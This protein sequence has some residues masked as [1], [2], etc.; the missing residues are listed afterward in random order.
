[1]EKLTAKEEEVMQVVWQA[2]K[3]FVKDFMPLI[4]EPKPHYNTL[5][6]IIRNLE[7]KGYISHKEYGGSYEYYPVVTKEEYRQAFIGKVIAN[8]FDNSYKSLVSF[9]A[10]QDK[11]SAEE[12]KEIVEMIQKKQ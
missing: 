9:F 11:I 1:M 5:S 10:R 4:P 2:G 6:T 12:L 7:E 8:Y 3:G